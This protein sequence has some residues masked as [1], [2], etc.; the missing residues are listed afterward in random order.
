VNSNS[1][2]G[3][4]SKKPQVRE[5]ERLF[6]IRK[7]A[8]SIQNHYVIN[9]TRVARAREINANTSTRFDR[10]IDCVTRFVHDMTRSADYVAAGLGRA[11]LANDAEQPFSRE[12]ADVSCVTF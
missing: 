5:T 2:A 9:R 4:L 7:R 6:D 10:G 3:S 1:R 11:A 8:N 12:G